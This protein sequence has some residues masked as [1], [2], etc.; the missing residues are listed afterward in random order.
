MSCPVCKSED[1]KLYFMDKHPLVSCNLCTHRWQKDLEIEVSYDDN[2]MNNYFKHNSLRQMSL[3]R[4]GL[5]EGFV[6]NG[7]SAENSVLDFGYGSG[8]FL[9]TMTLNGWKAYGIDVHGLNLGINEL[10]VDSLNKTKDENQLHIDVCTFFDSLEHLVNFDVI[11]T[12]S[13]FVN[14]FIVSVPI[15]YGKAEDIKCWKHYKPGEH[16]H[17]FTEDSIYMLFK[18]YEIFLDRFS[19]PED[20]VRGKINKT[21]PNITTFFFARQND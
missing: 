2:Y 3:L 13:K 8:D 20:I 7:R 5:V 9:R 12:L 10:S 15:Y 14:K 21:E 17:Y 19:Y 18:Q 1:Y 11:E 6:G 4:A 16:L